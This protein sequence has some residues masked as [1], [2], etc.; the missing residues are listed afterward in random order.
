MILDCDI[1]IV[2]LGISVNIL[3]SCSECYII[4]ARF[5]SRTRVI[6]VKGFNY[7]NLLC[8]TEGISFK[9][10]LLFTKIISNNFWGEALA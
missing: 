7:D 1:L 2:I 6:S 3:P 8:N 9:K 10:L 5:S 4:L